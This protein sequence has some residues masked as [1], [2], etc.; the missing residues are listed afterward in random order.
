MTATRKTLLII[1]VAI[2][3]AAAAGL[4]AFTYSWQNGQTGSAEPVVDVII[5]SLAV[6][7]SG[8]G[9]VNRALNMSAGSNTTLE[10]DIYSTETVVLNLTFHAYHLGRVPAPSTLLWHFNPSSLKV[11]DGSKAVSLL[12][13]IIPPNAAPGTYNAV[14]SAFDALNQTLVWG[15]FFQVNVNR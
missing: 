8:G 4:G 10:V 13:L 9:G 15:T 1:S 12:T 2:V 6:Y 3:I 5:P 11:Q 7:L 14:V